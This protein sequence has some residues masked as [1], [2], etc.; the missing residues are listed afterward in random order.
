MRMLRTFFAE[1]GLLGF[2][3]PYVMLVG[4]LLAVEIIFARQWPCLVPSWSNSPHIGP[5]LKDVTSYLLSA[6]VVMVGLLFPIAVGLVTL[7]VQ[8]GDASSTV[9]DIQ[10]YYGETLAYRIGASGIALSMVLAMQLVWPAHFLVHGLGFGT[11]SEF[12]KIVLTGIHLLWLLIN[13]SALW[14]FLLTSLSFMRPSER[15]HLRRRYAASVSIPQDLSDRLMRASYTNAGPSLLRESGESDNDDRAPSL[16]FGSD[17]GDWGQIEIASP[18]LSKMVLYDVWM[19][20]LG[21]AVRSWWKRCKKQE[22]D[23]TAQSHS[24]PTLVFAP[25]LQRPLPEG[26]TICR[27]SYGVPLNAFERFLIRQSFWFRRERS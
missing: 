1:R 9:S 23:A 6:Q 17:L 14:H 13:F 20:P 12:F 21:W 2:L 16:L 25:D 22:A 4:S 26:G 8:R 7:I 24:G 3:V 15:A 27:R 18:N 19:V 5:L 10:V 11:L